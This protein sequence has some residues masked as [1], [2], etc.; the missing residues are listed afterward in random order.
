MTIKN[1]PGT[2]VLAQHLATGTLIAVQ[3]KTTTAG[4]TW[5]LSAKDEIPTQREDAW[6]VLVALGGL[7]QRPDFFIVP[8]N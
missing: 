7:D 3:S 5:V 1:S 6:Y 8:R 2:D 4:D